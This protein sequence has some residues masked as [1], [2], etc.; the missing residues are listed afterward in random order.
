MVYICQTI[1]AIEI[2]TATFHTFSEAF[3]FAD[4]NSTKQ[5][6]QILQVVKI[7]E[8]NFIVNDLGYCNPNEAIMCTFHSGEFFPNTIYNDVQLWVN[9]QATHIISRMSFENF[10]RGDWGNI[11]D[12]QM[13]YLYAKTLN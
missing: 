7:S 1:K 12:N 4:F 2:M 10:G 6:G 3:K 8:E 9:E 11:T 13:A 5:N